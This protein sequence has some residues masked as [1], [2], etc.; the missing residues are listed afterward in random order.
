[1]GGESSCA[2]HNLTHP[3]LDGQGRC[4]WLPKLRILFPLPSCSSIFANDCMARYT[5]RTVSLP[6]CG[7]SEVRSLTHQFWSSQSLLLIF[8]NRLQRHL[9]RS[10]TVFLGEISLGIRI[11]CTLH[12]TISELSDAVLRHCLFLVFKFRRTLNRH[13]WC[14]WHPSKYS[15]SSPFLHSLRL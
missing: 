4:S 2:L 7:V 6:S 8:I 11:V 12:S 1:M 3:I 14:E 13:V 5:G 10:F 15:S 9:R